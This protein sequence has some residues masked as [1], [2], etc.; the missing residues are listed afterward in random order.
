MKSTR[1]PHESRLTKSRLSINGRR[2][3]M[4][5]G[6]YNMNMKM[7]NDATLIYGAIWLHA[8]NQTL[9]KKWGCANEIQINTVADIPLLFIMQNSSTTTTAAEPDLQQPPSTPPPT[10]LLQV[11]TVH[12][13]TV[14]FPVAISRVSALI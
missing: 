11:A 10:A 6:H 5:Y 2:W 7:T 1:T 3:T 14:Q 13:Y 4:E 12:Q 9:E 8:P